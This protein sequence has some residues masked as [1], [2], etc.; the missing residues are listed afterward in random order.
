MNNSAKIWGGL[1]ASDRNKSFFGR[2]FEIYSRFTWQL[3]LCS[4]KSPSIGVRELE[5][6]KWMAA[7]IFTHLG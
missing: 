1:F 2:A 6:H 7:Q 3:P 4:S 5:S